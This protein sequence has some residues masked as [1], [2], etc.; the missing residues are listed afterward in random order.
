MAAQQLGQTASPGVMVN[1]QR[2][3]RRPALS[4]AVLTAEHRAEQSPLLDVMLSGMVSSM[5]RVQP[6]EANIGYPV[7]GT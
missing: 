2:L 3:E 7:V 4:A 1:L 5:R 6:P